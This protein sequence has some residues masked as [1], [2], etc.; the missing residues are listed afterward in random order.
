MIN[1]DCGWLLTDFPMKGSVLENPVEPSETPPPYWSGQD[2]GIRRDLVWRFRLS[3]R[4]SQS[5]LEALLSMVEL[6]DDHVLERQVV[7]TARAQAFDVQLWPAISSI[8]PLTSVRGSCGSSRAIAPA[9]SLGGYSGAA[10]DSER[11]VVKVRQS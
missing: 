8:S 10:V 6:E 11:L 1:D 9:Y 3:G 7:P 2:D 4:R 5:T